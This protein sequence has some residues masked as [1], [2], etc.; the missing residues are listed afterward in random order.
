MSLLADLGFILVLLRR[1]IGE[2]KPRGSTTDLFPFLYFFLAKVLTFVLLVI[3]LRSN[4]PIVMNFSFSPVWPLVIGLGLILIALGPKARGLIKVWERSRLSKIFKGE[5]GVA[6][7]AI[8]FGV[9]AVFNSPRLLAG[10]WE[11]S[12]QVSLEGS[13]LTGVVFIVASLTVV[14]AVIFLVYQARVI[15]AVAFK[16]LSIWGVVAAGVWSV[17]V[18]LAYI[19]SPLAIQAI[20]REAYCLVT[21]CANSVVL[22]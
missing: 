19:S 21:F 12:Q 3:S 9:L 20:W 13:L 22:Q 7:L 11:I 16:H 10:S 15:A 17:N 6:W 8:S 2:G 5:G 18:F 4:L 1:I 14:A